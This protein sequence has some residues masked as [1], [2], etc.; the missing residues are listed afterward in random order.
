MG[1]VY[2]FNPP[3]EKFTS[4]EKKIEQYEDTWDLS[5]NPNQIAA[6]TRILENKLV[7]C[8][9]T[10]EEIGHVPEGFS[11]MFSNA[12]IHGNLE[13]KDREEGEG[14]ATT[15]KKHWMENMDASKNKRRVKVHVSISQEEVILIITDGGPGF[16]YKPI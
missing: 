1:D 16:D 7:Q 11:E 13:I 10:S 3:I 2:K 8:G 9:W 6:Y 15:G 5:S 12:I 14:W 4:S